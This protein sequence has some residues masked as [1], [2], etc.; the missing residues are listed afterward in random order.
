MHVNQGSIRMMKLATLAVIPA[1]LL[2]THIGV[3]LGAGGLFGEAVIV[4]YVIVMFSGLITMIHVE[5]W[6][7]PF[8][9]WR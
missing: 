9:R 6:E 2:L 8:L 1:W 5:A 7:E 4:T 3:T